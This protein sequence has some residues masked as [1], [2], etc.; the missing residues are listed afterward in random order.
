[1]NIEL[2]NIE[3]LDN[4]NELIDNSYNGTCFAYSWFL[5]LKNSNCILKILDE[6][7]NLEGFMPIFN[8]NNKKE[9]F[10]S[11]MYIPYGGPV[12]FK[13]PLDERKKIKYIRKIEKLLIEFM[14]DKYDKIDFS[15]D[16]KIIDIMAFIRNDFVPEVRYTYKID[17]VNDI[18]EIYSN[19]GSDRKKDIRK[20]NRKSL[21]FIVDKEMKYFSVNKAMKWEFNYGKESTVD[22]VN[23]YI[24][25]TINQERGM[26]F[27]ALSSS[28]DV[29]GAVHIA[30]DKNTA[31]IL[32]SYYNH[33]KDDVA[34]PFLYYNII[35]YLKE[36]QITNYLD[37]EGSVFEEIEDWN[38]SFGAYQSRFYNLHWNKNNNIDYK[39]VYNYGNKT[40]EN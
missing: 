34:I 27:V 21:Q 37:F 3:E 25:E 8:S 36:N 22:F 38:I 5:K 13:V 31:Y 23:K 12:I 10:Q 17:L 30:W 35:K 7:N 15:I 9:I 28:N 40:M 20:A 14:I 26:C 2:G 19:F 29:E 33:C 11:T 4:I 16:D 32:Y 39:E 18:N 1:M 24:K 6:N